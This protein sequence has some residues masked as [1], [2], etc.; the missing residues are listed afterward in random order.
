MQPSCT[1]AAPPPSPQ[2]TQLT[3]QR[4]SDNAYVEYS[5][6]TTDSVE[7]FDSNVFHQ[8]LAQLV[9]VD[10]TAV[11]LNVSPGS[12]R[13]DSLIRTVDQSDAIR[14]ADVLNAMDVPQAE[15]V[16]ETGVQKVFVATISERGSA[17]NDTSTQPLSSEWWVPAA[18]AVPSI[19]M[20]GLCAVLF[21]RFRRVSALSLRASRKTHPMVMP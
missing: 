21:A 13:V 15:R 3:I 7:A 8:K 20:L 11:T 4:S 2:L 17:G 10:P 12:V 18:I 6:I 19:C 9:D 14:I 16:F 5:V 1:L